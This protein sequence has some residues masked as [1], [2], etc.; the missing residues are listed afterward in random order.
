MLPFLP[1]SHDSR[2]RYYRPPCAR[3]LNAPSGMITQFGPDSL[4]GTCQANSDGLSDF[5][6]SRDTRTFQW[7]CRDLSGTIQGPSPTSICCTG[8]GAGCDCSSCRYP[9][10]RR[11]RPHFPI[12]VRN[13]D[14]PR[15]CCSQTLQACSQCLTYSEGGDQTNPAVSR[16]NTYRCANC[17]S[18]SP[19]DRAL[20]RN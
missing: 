12:P 3:Y 16:M 4:V 15:F 5:I 7:N 1:P 13:S 20:L 6:C 10:R 18:L 19:Q 9:R 2:T 17:V 14:V 8:E 11:R